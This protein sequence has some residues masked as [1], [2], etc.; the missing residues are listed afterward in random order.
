MNIFVGGIQFGLISSLGLVPGQIVIDAETIVS[1]AFVGLSCIV[2]PLACFNLFGN[3][4][5]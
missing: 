1:G 3:F 4:P 2:L 5:D